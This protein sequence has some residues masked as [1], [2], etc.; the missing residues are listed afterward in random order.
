MIFHR[1]SELIDEAVIWSVLTQLC[2]GLHALTQIEDSH[3]KQLVHRCLK[4]ACITYDA[5]SRKVKIG[6]FGFGLV[7]TP[8]YATPVGFKVVIILFKACI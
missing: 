2:E 5:K 7:S 3:R 1:K 8:Y 4:P 6:K